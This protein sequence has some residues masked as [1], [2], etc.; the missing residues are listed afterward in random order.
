MNQFIS[1]KFLED[2]DILTLT[3]FVEQSLWY[4]LGVYVGYCQCSVL[5]VLEPVCA[6]LEFTLI[7]SD[8]LDLCNKNIMNWHLP[9]IIEEIS[10]WDNLMK[11]YL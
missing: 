7:E 11:L 4:E 9:M 5:A 3:Q 10:Q 1:P 2:I 6:D 8:Y